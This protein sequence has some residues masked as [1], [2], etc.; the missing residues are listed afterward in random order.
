VDET[1]GVLTTQKIQALLDTAFAPEVRSRRDLAAALA[2]RG[3]PITRHGVEA[4]FRHVDSNYNFKR[5]SLSGA[6]PSYPI[7][8]KRWS[9]VIDVFGIDPR[10][11][12]RGDVPFR[13]WCLEQRPRRAGRGGKRVSSALPSGSVVARDPEFAAFRDVFALAATGTPA[14]LL[15]EG[16]PGVGKSRLLE[17]FN[18][19][20]DDADCLRLNAGCAE[21]SEIPLLPIVDL[22]RLNLQKISP[23][24]GGYIEQFEAIYTDYIGGRTS[25]HS[26]P[27]LF[28]QLS[29]LLLQMAQERTLVLIVDD[30]HWADDA[31]RRFLLYLWQ[32]AATG[33][34]NRIAVVGAARPEANDGWTA[35]TDRLR[36]FDS[37]QVRRIGPMSIDDV[38]ALLDNATDVPV[39]VRL[40]K[41]VWEQSLGNPFYA[42]EILRCL[43]QDGLLFVANGRTDTIATPEQVRLQG[44]IAAIYRERFGAFTASTR[45]LL[46]Y[47]AALASPF[48]LEQI[49]LLFPKEPLQQLLDSIEEAEHEEFLSY[50]NDRFQ[51]AHPLI[52]QAIDQ[53]A[54]ET[55]RARI[56]CNIADHLRHDTRSPSEYRD[57]EVA[58]HL[59]KGR[60]VADQNLLVSYCYRAALLAKKLAA[61][62]Q[63]M[64]FAHTALEVTDTSAISDEQR[65]TLLSSLGGALHQSGRPVEALEMLQQAKQRFA[66]AGDHV[67]YAGVLSEIAKIRGNFGIAHPN[68]MDE[69]DEL[70]RLAAQLAPAQP[71]LA[72]RL[73]DTVSARYM[74]ASKPTKALEFSLKAYDTVRSQAACEERALAAISAGLAHLQTLDVHAAE[75]Y[76]SEG[77]DTANALPHPPSAARALQRL[78]I[79]HFLRGAPSNVVLATKRIR[80]V[81]RHIANTGEFTL[82]LAMQLAVHALRG[83]FAAAQTIFDE[84]IELACTSGYVWGKPPLVS[85]FCYMR[86]RQGRSVEA[87][88][89]VD[90]L[91]HGERRDMGRLVTQLRSFIAASRDIGEYHYLPF[92]GA[93]YE[94]MRCYRYGMDLRTATRVG[95]TDRVRTALAA[96][97]LA[98]A[99]GIVFTA[100]W[101]FAIPALLAEGRAFLGDESA[102]RYHFSIA[103]DLVLR[104]GLDA[105][106]EPLLELGSTL[107]AVDDYALESLRTRMAEIAC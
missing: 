61:W 62:D 77:L 16:E 81:G 26:H 63:M 21:D 41:F 105:E 82:A 54:P 73:L 37:V 91:A 97:E 72:S 99:R 87:L 94:V 35:F 93:P 92:D 32:N 47:A 36:R 85:A 30:L 98:A 4:W 70:Q 86:H 6:T 27:Q 43:R 64:L 102:A 95:D 2:E 9:A 96:L 107:T 11:L 44:D 20:L 12:E 75:A 14:M 67:A 42:L 65:A 68:E 1:Q 40:R 29:A 58:H 80:E 15:I 10:D 83:E 51:F 50:H 13:K 3:E 103:T 101:P 69:L 19:L 24:E 55:R 48:T 60:M 31:T 34:G 18:A 100:G 74:Y 76:F 78:S 23:L 33:S 53:L 28:V 7:P 71:R 8:R 45:Q 22:V 56:H 66:E 38:G 57:I 59:R 106:L 17:E 39:S 5:E 49:Q 84:G 52:R 46:Q 90:E 25:W 88:A 104:L 89:M 79:V